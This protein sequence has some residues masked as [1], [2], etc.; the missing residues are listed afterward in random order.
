M[1]APEPGDS[2][3]AP[4]PD[5]PREESTAGRGPALSL[6]TVRSG[7]SRVLEFES[8]SVLVATILLA[9]AIGTLHPEFFAWSQIKDVLSQSVYVGILAAGIEFLLSMREIRVPASSF[10]PLRLIIS[11]LRRPGG[12]NPWGSPPS[13]QPPCV[14]HA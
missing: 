9:V 1:R 8:N 7:G 13:R 4:E 6:D 14:R 12:G 3:G 10:F 11:S 2:G 5:R